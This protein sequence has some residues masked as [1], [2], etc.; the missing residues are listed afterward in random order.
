MSSTA[1]SAATSSEASLQQ[2]QSKQQRKTLV[3]KILKR[4]TSL[5]PTSH[6]QKQSPSVNSTVT[7]NLKNNEVA[8]SEEIDL[9]RNPLLQRELQVI[10]EDT[11][12]LSMEEQP[13]VTENQRKN[14]R[15]TMVKKAIHYFEDRSNRSMSE[16]NLYTRRKNL[17]VHLGIDETVSMKEVQKINTYCLPVPSS[18]LP[19]E[20][21]EAIACTARN[22]D[23]STTDS[24]RNELHSDENSQN[25]PQKMQSSQQRKNSGITVLDSVDETEDEE[26]IK[27]KN[28]AKYLGMK[29][30]VSASISGQGK[31]SDGFQS[32]TSLER[33]DSGKTD[34]DEKSKILFSKN[35]TSSLQS[36]T[37]RGTLAKLTTSNNS[38]SSESRKSSK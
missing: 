22:F 38:S 27:T 9:R 19:P 3:S 24:G 10:R 25:K 15:A 12:V 13:E 16:D 20:A 23:K 37:K 7:L 34:G 33:K 18:A 1:T 6:D 5:Q 26:D 36:P 17:A 14:K 8:D 28:L 21:Q 30:G 2:Q 31:L 4:T 32:K 11:E 35:R 29:D